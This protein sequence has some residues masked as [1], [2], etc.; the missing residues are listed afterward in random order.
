LGD[1][2][3]RSTGMIP[4]MRALPHGYTNST[5]GDGALVVKR[6][7]G[8]ERQR[9]RDTE[10][11]ALTGLAGRLPVP[12]VIS[13]GPDALT[14]THLS[15]VHGQD[16]IA[17]GHAGPVLHACGEMLRRIQTVDRR[18]ATV[19]VH[20]DYGPNNMLFDQ[21][22][23]AVTAVLDWE[24]ATRG[25]PVADLAWCEWILR[26]HHQGE[27]RALGALFD[28]YGHRP[29]LAGRRDAAAARCRQLRDIFTSHRDVWQRRLD[30]TR[31]W[32]DH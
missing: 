22:T 4:A 24:W 8:P 28:G 30:D 5:H 21:E 1:I 27:V 19:L 13:A 25:D 17:A 2:P 10:V 12:R 29:P 18:A 11:A 15:G 7:E 31:S 16:L 14:M 20:G 32:T 9:R 26:T 3:G 23:F 6:Y